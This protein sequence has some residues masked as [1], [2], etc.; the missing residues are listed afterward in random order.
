[1]KNYFDLVFVSTGDGG[2]GECDCLRTC[3]FIV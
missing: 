2:A 1:V 3:E